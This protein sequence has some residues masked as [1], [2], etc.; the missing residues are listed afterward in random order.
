MFERYFYNDDGTLV[1][2]TIEWSNPYSSTGA[3]D[4]KSYLYI[5]SYLPFNHRY[6]DVSTAN[7]K[8]GTLT[9]DVWYNSEWT[10][11]VDIVDMTSTSGISLA[12]SGNIYFTVDT[13]KTWEI[14]DDSSEITELSTTK[15]YNSYWMRLGY[16]ASV[17]SAT[18]INYIGYK[19]CED[20]DLYTLYP[21]FNNTALMTQFKSGK[22]NWND[23]TISASKIIVSD[24]TS[25]ELIHSKDQIMD[26]SRYQQ[27]C[28]HKTAE[29]IYAGLGT[30]YRD[31]KNDAAKEYANAMNVG[32]F[33]IDIN[34]D[35]KLD[36]IEKVGSKISRMT[37]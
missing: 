5:S 15:V 33:N 11:V 26:S 1:D 12:K 24:L 2:R 14:E 36:R 21:I 31:D 17:D 10:S 6:F 32:N 34:A 7:D 16:N 13:L 9:I 4:A 22:T 28:I 19:F 18:V 37:R 35:G 20:V 25:R 3:W 23:Q 27:S 30:S 29:I 8:S